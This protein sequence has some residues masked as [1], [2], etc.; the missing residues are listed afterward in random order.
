M[1]VH[2]VKFVLNILLQFIIESLTITVFGGAI[3]VFLGIFLA[4]AISSYAK[5]QTVISYTAILYAIG[6][7]TLTGLIF[8]LYPAGKAASTD[9]I[10][11]L[12]V[13]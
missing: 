4:N 3:G 2:P 6:V 8:G 10:T 1:P 9:P 11:A 5:W 7:S 13:E 12:K